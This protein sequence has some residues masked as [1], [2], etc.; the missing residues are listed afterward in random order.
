MIGPVDGLSQCL[1]G[2]PTSG[3]GIHAHCVNGAIASACRPRVLRRARRRSRQSR[4]AEHECE[5]NSWRPPRSDLSGE[6]PSHSR[7]ETR[8]TGLP[9]A[10]PPKGLYADFLALSDPAIQMARQRAPYVSSCQEVLA[11]A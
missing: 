11:L 10:E 4:A 6:R 7:G 5:R 9:F 1:P 2:R 3:N 8:P